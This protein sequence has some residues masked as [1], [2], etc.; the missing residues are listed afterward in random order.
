MESNRALLALSALSQA[1]RSAVVRLLVEHEPDGLA[2]GEIARRLGV[3]PNTLSSHLGIL[4]RAGLIT[5]ER[6][7]RSIVHRARIDGIRSLADFLLGDCC[8]AHPEALDVEPTASPRSSRSRSS[9]GLDHPYDVLFLCA[10]DTARSIFAESLLRA[11]G[12][13]RFVAHSA[14]GRAKREVDPI[15]IRV[16]E[17]AGH[18]TEGLRSKSWDE[19]TGPDAPVMDFVFTLCDSVAGEARPVLPGH[20]ITAHWG[21]ADPA[22]EA[23]DVEKETAFVAA[24]RR[25]E[26]RV[27][28]FAA[29]PIADLDATALAER[30]R[31]IGRLDGATTH[32]GTK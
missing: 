15:A 10:D 17:K 9:A 29:L 4:A 22:A 25:L 31:E 24:F 19:F 32:I 5:P 8:R 26:N 11:L 13:D 30:L 12:G 3:P 6:R 14:G 28:A 18:P 23:T 16:L 2:V 1:T 20:P 21:I 27:S 7:G